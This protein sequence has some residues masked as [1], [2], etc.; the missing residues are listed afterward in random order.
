MKKNQLI[1]LFLVMSVL[2]ISQCEGNS[3]VL[4]SRVIT[5]HWLKNWLEN[6]S[7]SPPCW[8]GITPGKTTLEE[9]NF[10]IT[11]IQNVEVSSYNFKTNHGISTSWGIENYSISGT[12]WANNPDEVVNKIIINLMIDRIYLKD[13]I[14]YF[15]NPNYIHFNYCQMVDFT[16]YCDVL[17]WTQKFGHKKRG[18]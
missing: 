9:A 16:K 8:E 3:G 5:S 15:G 17:L 12:I 7:C 11:K 6:P 4:N 14:S 2:L 18:N 1:I 13:I 10:L